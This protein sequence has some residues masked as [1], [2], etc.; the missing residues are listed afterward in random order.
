M[1]VE[2]QKKRRRRV[3]QTMSLGER[4]LQTARE[5][6]DQAKRLP[7]GIEQARQLRRARE[8]EAIA[9]LD[10]FLTA[11]ARSNPPRSR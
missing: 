4:L 5:A 2:T 1:D 6:R 11:P 3:K 10:R 9:E 7:P 8:A